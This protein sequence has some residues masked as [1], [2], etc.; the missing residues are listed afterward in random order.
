M[1]YQRD[2]DERLWWIVGS[3]DYRRDGYT[4]ND[5]KNYNSHDKNIKGGGLE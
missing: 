3:L 1:D 5:W 4:D 2:S